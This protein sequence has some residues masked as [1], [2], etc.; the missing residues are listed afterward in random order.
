M[1]SYSILNGTIP[2]LLNTSILNNGVNL[3]VYNTIEGAKIGLLITNNIIP[4]TLHQIFKCS[5]VSELEEGEE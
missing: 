4:C 3:V 1:Y 2:V 5:N